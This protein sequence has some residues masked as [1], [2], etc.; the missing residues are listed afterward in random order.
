MKLIAPGIGALGAGVCAWGLFMAAALA[1]AGPIALGVADAGIYSADVGFAAQ[2][3]VRNAAVFAAMCA[4]AHLIGTR[5]GAPRVRIGVSVGA[6]VVI[7]GTWVLTQGR[8]A[9]ALGLAADPGALAAATVAHTIPELA[10]LALPLCVC[11]GGGRVGA[12]LTAGGLI[13]LVACALAEAY[14]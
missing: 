4:L 10:T 13:A 14:I 1:S 7:L 8:V 2:V 5:A 12:K 3:A 6:L 9:G 11:A